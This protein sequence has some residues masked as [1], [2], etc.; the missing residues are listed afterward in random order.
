[1][2]K[3]DLINQYVS[4]IES[5]R[6][7]N[8]D[9]LHDAAVRWNEL[10]NNRTD[11][12]SKQLFTIASFVL[13]LSFF[14]LSNTNILSSINNYGKIALVL[15]WITFIF[16]L[17]L[18]LL[19]IAKEANFFNDWAEQENKR[20]KVYSEGIFTLNPENAYLRLQEMNKKANKLTKMSSRQS[21]WRLYLQEIF[22]ILGV[23]FIGI[24]L[25]NLLFFGKNNINSLFVP[26][27]RKNYTNSKLNLIH[28]NNFIK[29]NKTK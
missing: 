27:Q 6:K 1:M 24:T 16:S 20:G 28:S 3:N 10:A 26:N 8:K 23:C 13:P 22:L 11:Q 12:L 2:K 18:G 25:I 14:P 19:H 9:L 5:T 7:E 4:F 17:I 15:A 21:L 29:F